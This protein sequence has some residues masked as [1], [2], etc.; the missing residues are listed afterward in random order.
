MSKKII[1][2]NHNIFKRKKTR[3]TMSISENDVYCENNSFPQIN[4]YIQYSPNQDPQRNFW[5]IFLF[6]KTELEKLQEL[7]KP[8]KSLK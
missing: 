4:L 7:V 6:K 1:E 5:C 8:N 3:Q 2:K